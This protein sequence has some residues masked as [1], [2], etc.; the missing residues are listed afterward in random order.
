MNN[1]NSQDVSTDYSDSSNGGLDQNTPQN[2]DCCL[3]SSQLS[4][5]NDF[6]L[7]QTDIETLDASLQNIPKELYIRK[8]LEMC[9]NNENRICWNRNL[10]C[11]RARLQTDCPKGS[12]IKRKITK[13]GLSAQKIYKRLLYLVIVYPM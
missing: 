6:I 13:S 3:V 11:S 5:S 4:T 8:L 9:F 10:L 12:L 7:Q 1:F 2:I